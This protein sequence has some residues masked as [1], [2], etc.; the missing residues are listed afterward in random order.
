MKARSV[1]MRSLLRFFPLPLHSFAR[2]QICDLRLVRPLV[3]ARRTASRRNSGVGLFPFPIEHLLVPQL[4]LS[5]FLGQVQDA[6]V[7]AGAHRV[8]MVRA[9]VLDG[10]LS[11]GRLEA[12]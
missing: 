3:S 2:A 5:T 1:A 10:R 9:A 6:V 11:A 8:A 4:V 12:A 7:S